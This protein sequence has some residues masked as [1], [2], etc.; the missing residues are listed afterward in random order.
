MI[1]AYHMMVCRAIYRNAVASACIIEMII[2]A[3]VCESIPFPV[4]HIIIFLPFNCHLCELLHIYTV[5]NVNR[6][7]CLTSIACLLNNTSN[8]ILE[9]ITSSWS[10]PY[11]EVTSELLY[12]LTWRSKF[13]WEFC[14]KRPKTCCIQWS[15]RTSCINNSRI[16]IVVPS[17]IHYIRIQ[18][19][20]FCFV[21]LTVNFNKRFKNVFIINEHH[22][23][24]P[25][26][27]LCTELWRS[28]DWLD[29]LEEVCLNNFLLCTS[30][31]SCNCLPCHIFSILRQ[32]V[33]C[34]QSL[35]RLTAVIAHKSSSVYDLCIRCREF[36]SEEHSLNVD[37]LS[38]VRF[39]LFHRNNS[40]LISRDC[41]LCVGRCHFQRLKIDIVDLSFCH[42][43][44][45][46]IDLEEFTHEVIS[47]IHYDYFVDRILYIFV[48]IRFERKCYFLSFFLYSVDF[49][50]CIFDFHCVIAVF[51]L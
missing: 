4:V 39:E 23:I 46:N 41:P 34:L 49:C 35:E 51:Q 13:L 21:Q 3:T 18:W 47:F 45:R 11:T 38:E 15:S 10:N 31:R 30:C 50:C 5:C 22:I 16:I 36:T 28:C 40:T 24:E 48:S 26:V 17:V 6:S 29:I 2:L 33:V 7:S 14:I 8:M 9:V 44:I 12:K 20:D 1:T 25:W 37:R 32:L 27:V 43:F 42:L 19:A